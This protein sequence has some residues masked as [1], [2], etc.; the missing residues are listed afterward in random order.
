MVL[1]RQV[2]AARNSA[3]PCLLPVL[4]PLSHGSPVRPRAAVWLRVPC[5]GPKSLARAGCGGGR[6]FAGPSRTARGNTARGTALVEL[7]LGMA[8]PSAGSSL[9]TRGRDTGR[10]DLGGFVGTL[11]FFSRCGQDNNSG[12]MR[13]ACSGERPSNKASSSAEG[14]RAFKSQPTTKLNKGRR[15]IWMSK[16]KPQRARSRAPSERA[17]KDVA[18]ACCCFCHGT[19]FP[20]A[21]L[22]FAI[23][24]AARAWANFRFSGPNTYTSRG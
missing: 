8:W 22:L 19:A 15:H 23:L 21:D 20:M 9:S 5:A 3:A 4:R 16:C 18:S 2:Q 7:A 10:K 13:A 14:G 24:R 17:R 1:R 12:S 11:E 6:T